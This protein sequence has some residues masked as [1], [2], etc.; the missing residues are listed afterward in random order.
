ME[1]DKDEDVWLGWDPNWLVV[2]VN[3]KSA[4]VGG[5]GLGST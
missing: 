5:V 2:G 4:E 3:E 1:Y